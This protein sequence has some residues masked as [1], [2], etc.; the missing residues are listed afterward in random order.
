MTT[1][2]AVTATLPDNNMEE[3][4]VRKIPICSKD[5]ATK[6]K[7]T[8]RSSKYVAKTKALKKVCGLSASASSVSTCEAHLVFF[9]LKVISSALERRQLCAA[10]AGGMLG[11][12]NNKMPAT[13]PQ[14]SLI[15]RKA[16]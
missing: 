5:N 3:G 2:P 15:H 16:A 4:S 1:P 10:S 7:A 14:K 8:A 9:V 11:A 13:T 12:C 6:N